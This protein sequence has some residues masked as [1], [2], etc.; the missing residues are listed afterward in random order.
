M[1]EELPVS[2]NP[3][4]IL[5]A[6]VHVARFKAGEHEFGLIPTS[7]LTG[8][9]EQKLASGERR[10]FADAILTLLPGKFSTY[11]NEDGVYSFE[12]LAPGRYVVRLEEQTL[13]EGAIAGNV[14]SVDIE[15]RADDERVL[16]PFVFE[17]LI[18]EK[19]IQPVLQNEQIISP[20]RPA[21]PKPSRRGVSG[22][23]ERRQK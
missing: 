3:P 22:S 13:P 15:L 23:S 18:E 5:A 4:A 11:T 21:K 7:R 16:D 20:R 1:L 19:P 2:F 6:T 9:V 12:N 14:L 8:R 10:P 17:L